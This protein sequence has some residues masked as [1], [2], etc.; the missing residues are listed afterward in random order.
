MNHLKSLIQTPQFGKI[1]KLLPKCRNVAAVGHSLGGS[2]ASLFIGCLHTGGEGEAKTD[3]DTIS[4]DTSVTPELLKESDPHEIDCDPAI[5]KAGVC[6]SDVKTT[7][8]ASTTP[9]TSVSP[10]P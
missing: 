1:R 2:D 9:S 8:T 4:W 6:G 5:H 3:Y 10:T 7:L